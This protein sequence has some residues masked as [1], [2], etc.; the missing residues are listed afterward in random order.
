MRSH[1]RLTQPQWTLPPLAA[2]AQK[3]SPYQN[4]SSQSCCSL[5]VLFRSRLSLLYES[6]ATVC[7]FLC[8][9]CFVACLCICLRLD[10]V[11]PTA[12]VRAV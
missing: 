6:V 9:V 11:Y 3:E 12:C 8:C 10:A 5:S 7:L 4:N 2:F 1:I